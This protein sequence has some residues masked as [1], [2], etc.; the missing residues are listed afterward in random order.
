MI[1]RL[2]KTAYHPRKQLG[3]VEARRAHNPEVT[4]SKPVAAMVFFFLLLSGGN[5]FLLFLYT[6]IVFQAA[7]FATAAHSTSSTGA[8]DACLHS[9]KHKAL[10][11][12]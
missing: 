7:C 1:R 3:A 2:C 11:Q 6:G 12:N 4:G 5:L 8:C 9:F 10:L